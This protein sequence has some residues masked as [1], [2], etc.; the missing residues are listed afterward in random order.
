MPNIRGRVER[1]ERRRGKHLP[2]FNIILCT[3]ECADCEYVKM[4]EDLLRERLT[5]GSSTLIIDALRLHA[6][7]PKPCPASRRMDA[8]MQAQKELRQSWR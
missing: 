4:P 5:P 7:D 1:L 2:H 3:E 6:D 8:I